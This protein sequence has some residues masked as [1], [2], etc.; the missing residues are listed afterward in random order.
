MGSHVS[1]ATDVE[2]RPGVPLDKEAEI[3]PAL[4][5]EDDSAVALEMA[6]L[7]IISQCQ[8]GN[9]RKKYTSSS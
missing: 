7:R 4:E 8:I 5:S 6:E 3:V 9:G 2:E 1:E